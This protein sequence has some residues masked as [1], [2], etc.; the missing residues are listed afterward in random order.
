MAETKIPLDASTGLDLYELAAKGYLKLTGRAIPNENGYLETDFASSGFETE[1]TASCDTTLT[2]TVSSW[3]D[4]KFRGRVA[5]H[6]DREAYSFVT[7]QGD[8]VEVKVPL[9]RGPHTLRVFKESII[10]Y[11]VEDYTRL[12]RIQFEGTV[13]RA[14]PN[15]PLYVVFIGASSQCGAHADFPY[16]P[17]TIGGTLNHFVSRSACFRTAELLNADL[18]V[19]AK[20]GIG[21]WMTNT[22]EPVE[23]KVRMQDLYPY[24]GY[25]TRALGIPYDFTKERKPD[26]I[27]VSLSGNDRGTEELRDIWVNEARKFILFLKQSHGEDVPIVWSIGAGLDVLYRGLRDAVETDPSLSAYTDLYVTECPSN[28]NGG[29]ALRRQTHGHPDAL[30]YKEQGEQLYRYIMT[31]GILRKKLMPKDTKKQGTVRLNVSEDGVFSADRDLTFKNVTLQAPSDVSF[32]AEGHR[33]VFDNADF[34]SDAPGGKLNVYAH[35]SDRRS[36]PEKAAAERVSEV[37]FLHGVYDETTGFGEIAAAGGAN[38]WKKAPGSVCRVVVSEGAVLSDAK[39]MS[40]PVSVKRAEVEIETLG[41]LKT[42][43][44]VGT[45]SGTENAEQT[46]D[47]DLSFVISGGHVRGGFSELGDDVV[48]NGNVSFTMNGGEIH[49]PAA[50]TAEENSVVFGGGSLR[51]RVNGSVTNVL[52]D[53]KIYVRAKEGVEAAVYMA[54]RKESFISG[55]VSNTL[56]FARFLI[57]RERAGA[58]SNEKCGVCFTMETGAVGTEV[59]N[60]VL[61]AVFELRQVMGN[62]TFG[63]TGNASIPKITNVLGIPSGA[64]SVGPLFHVKEA[65][66]GGNETKLGTPSDRPEADACST[67]TVLSTTVYGGRLAAGR[68]HFS[69]GSASGAV[70]GSVETTVHKGYYLGG[71]IR[72]NASDAPVYGHVRVTVNGGLFEGV[73]EEPAAG[74]IHGGLECIVNDYHDYSRATNQPYPFTVAA[75]SALK[76]C[77][78]V[79]ALSVTVNGGTFHGPFRL[80]LPETRIDGAC[81]FAVNG[82]WFHS[83]EANGREGYLFGGHFQSAPEEAA[84]A[85]RHGLAQGVF[86]NTEELKDIEEYAFAVTEA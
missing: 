53:A 65:F 32:Y 56:D 67:E 70:Y 36:A 85:P 49:A 45:F 86:P 73:D 74:A 19:V 81:R 44:Y 66:L 5:V 46:V 18:N 4:G 72:L 28:A 40:A 59:R 52:K 83:I 1:I 8:G 26:L 63:S 24:S 62:V 20:G 64:R 2:L 17:G 76:G 84:L 57:A 82:G 25:R 31:E 43:R 78:D 22:Q 51:T 10:E 13:D 21:L 54:G 38:G 77:K 3:K 55:T 47:A 23:G 69:T 34:K 75:L 11:A 37:V 29:A 80:S 30:D 9:T 48:V 61:H 12:D 15:K 60:R 33:I 7:E 71:R 14:T 16:W 39:L 42:S 50:K 6:V 79:P 58:E 68:L 35:A 27:V 41:V